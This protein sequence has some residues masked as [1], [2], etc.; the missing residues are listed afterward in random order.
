MSEQERGELLRHLKVKWATLNAGEV[1]RTWSRGCAL[2]AVRKLGASSAA[3]FASRCGKL[4]GDSE[5]AAHVH[6]TCLRCL[7][8]QAADW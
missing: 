6:G 2:A 4:P 7:F 5:G 8:Q 3:G 1:M